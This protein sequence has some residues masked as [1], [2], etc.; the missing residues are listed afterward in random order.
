MKL[1][2]MRR[3]RS[4]QQGLC[5]RC[6]LATDEMCYFS[7]QKMPLSLLFINKFAHYLGVIFR[8][9]RGFFIAKPARLH[10]CKHP[11]CALLALS[12]CL[13]AGL[14]ASAQAAAGRD[15]AAAMAPISEAQVPSAPL[16]AKPITITITD[17]R[18][19]V[20]IFQK[21]P[22][23]I[24]SLLPSLTET[25]CALGQCHRLVGVDRYSNWPEAVTHLPS[26][27]GGLDP[28]IEAVLAQR[29]DLVLLAT[30][31]RAADR[32][33]ALGVPVVA[34]EP[35]SHADVQRVLAT[36]G[37]LLAVSDAQRVWREI[38]ASVQ[39]A[40]S[41]IPPSVQGMRVY[42]EINSVPYAAGASS[43]IGETLT[44]LRLQNI[45]PV[46]LGPFPKLNPEFVV[47]ANPDGIMV[48]QGSYAGMGQR[49]GWSA[50]TALQKNRVC[51]F[52]PQQSDSLVR[53][54]PRMAEGA[55]LMA[56]CISRWAP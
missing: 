35:R 6:L 13:L 22:Q 1:L 14:S 33:E 30:S 40:A 26:M 52:T 18:G 34:L 8:L 27:G 15:G 50:L 41:A 46:A 39:A 29:P 49:P 42:F 9:F 45:V 25:I 3:C 24:V 16:S 43:F 53:A 19:R 38:D 5:V 31:A 28:Q 10:D 17:D 12:V 20:V 44:R 7:C 36:V 55:Q 47:R 56:Q 51:V 21:V 11:Q 32:L 54:G 2:Q 4:Y 23:R 37:Q 48:G